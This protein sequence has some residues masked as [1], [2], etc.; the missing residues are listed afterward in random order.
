MLSHSPM[1]DY[2]DPVAKPLFNENTVYLIDGSGYIFRAFFAIRALRSKAGLPPNA[3]FGFTNMLIKLLKEHKPRYI[4]IAFDRKEP[5]FRHHLY[6]D[7]KA[8][9]SSPPEDLVP[10]FELIHRV[11]EA[12]NIKLLSVAG[13]EADDVIGTMAKRVHE[14]GWQVVIVT[15]DKDLMQLVD[16]RTFLLDE[17][18]A[19]R[20]GSEQLIDIDAVK[21]EL[22]VWPHQVVDMLA[23]AGD[24]SD[25]VPGIA[26][27]G[28]KTAVELINEFG[29]LE[30]IIHCAPLIKQ[31]SR[32]EK[33]IDGQG[34][35]FLSKKLVTINTNVPI[36]CTIADLKYTGIAHDKAR[37]LFLELDF[38]RLLQDATLFKS[39]MATDATRESAKVASEVDRTA[40]RSITNRDE[41]NKVL[42][43]LSVVKKVAVDTETD[44]LN[45][46]V[47]NLVGIALAWGKN[48]ACYIP[49]AHD[50]SVISAQLDLPTVRD[51]L[52]ALL[53]D[54]NKTIVAQ[55]AKFDQK[56]LVRHGFVDF[57]IG[58]DPMLAS[59]L[60]HQDRE[61]HNL[62]DLSLKYLHHQPITF[63]EICGAKKS[64]ISFAK[65]PLQLA[66]DYSAEDADIA[67]RLE[68]L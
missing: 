67:L 28:K 33:V 45:A 65:V 61:R 9:R 64:Q 6:P 23:L 24:S 34:D 56:I 1:S 18:R 62:D 5:T 13:Y 32:R 42:E 10:Q 30:K 47:A 68:E 44:G 20:N 16:E 22:G 39:D 19:S 41:F 38:N 57:K 29:P 48:L 14:Q 37:K 17:L 52:N 4:A 58:G 55:N 66:T 35:A 3:V 59:Y 46:I 2:G 11:V 43:E 7:Y 21:H 8:N 49:I 40:Y 53:S 31:K 50:H 12:F 60:L 26:G 25:N 63:E 54:P 27:I 15:G 51:G 36:D